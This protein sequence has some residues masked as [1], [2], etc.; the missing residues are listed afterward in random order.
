MQTAVTKFSGVMIDIIFKARR[1][2]GEGEKDE[3]GKSCDCSTTNENAAMCI[4][5]CNN[6]KGAKII[7]LITYCQLRES[8]VDSISKFPF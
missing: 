5:E 1:N 8:D 4:F 6:S 3:G 2:K 7:K